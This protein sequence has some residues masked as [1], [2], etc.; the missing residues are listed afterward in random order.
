MNHN[1][2]HFVVFPNN[3]IDNLPTPSLTLEGFQALLA[4][5][6]VPKK[7]YEH[8]VITSLLGKILERFS[9]LTLKEMEKLLENILTISTNAPA[10]SLVL[11]KDSDGT[12]Y[13]YA[14]YNNLLIYTKQTFSNNLCTTI[15]KH[16]DETGKRCYIEKQ[17]YPLSSCL[18][19]KSEYLEQQ[20]Q[21][22]STKKEKDELSL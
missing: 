22:S 18:S 16:F 13:S 9:S 2:Q 5:R 6:G 1:K 20:F 8:P 21:I 11:N 17:H 4:H 7:L 3:S 12:I 14:L 15:T 10:F 19:A